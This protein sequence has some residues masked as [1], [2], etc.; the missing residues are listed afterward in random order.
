ML[1]KLP[2]IEITVTHCLTNFPT[3]AIDLEIYRG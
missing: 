1:L 2:V 3:S